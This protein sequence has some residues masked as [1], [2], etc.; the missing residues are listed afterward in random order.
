[1]GLKVELRLRESFLLRSSV[2]AHE[3]EEEERTR[4]ELPLFYH[5]NVFAWAVRIIALERDV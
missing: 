4:G 2:I 3:V 1:L 5:A